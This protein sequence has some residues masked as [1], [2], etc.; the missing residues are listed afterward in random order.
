[1]THRAPADTVQ[2]NILTFVP[3]GNPNR[4][5]EG[6][7][8][9][10]TVCNILRGRFSPQSQKAALRSSSH[11]GPTGCGIRSRNLAIETF[12]R[13]GKEG[14]PE[15][16]SFAAAEI[17]RAGLGNGQLRTPRDSIEAVVAALLNARKDWRDTV[18]TAFPQ[19]KLKAAK[20][21]KKGDTQGDESA[22]A[23]E[24]MNVP[25]LK[26]AIADMFSPKETGLSYR[27]GKGAEASWPASWAVGGGVFAALSGSDE[28]LSKNLMTAFQADQPLL[29][30]PRH[31]K[32]KQVYR[33][34][35]R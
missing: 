16:L 35:R 7:P 13:L 4:D 34:C 10:M 22:E 3:F 17:V 24:G 23:E 30:V 19:I 18:T 12:E 2:A 14:V 26:A 5:E 33:A 21:A 9:T 15:R 20:G 29:L 28:D 25:A 6:H 8:K 11:L 1:M 32:W 27:I 31:L